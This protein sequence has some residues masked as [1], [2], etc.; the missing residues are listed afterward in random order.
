MSAPTLNLGPLERAREEFA[1]A[2]LALVEL[3]NDA[4]GGEMPGR[5]VVVPH[6]SHDCPS[7]AVIL[8]TGDVAGIVRAV[9]AL[10]G[11]TH[12]VDDIEVQFAREVADALSLAY[13]RLF[14]FVY[15]AARDRARRGGQ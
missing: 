9:E 5:I 8:T 2:A 7:L 3:T 12:D 14:D 1:R 6:D 11:T 10:D 4:D 15:Q 13:P